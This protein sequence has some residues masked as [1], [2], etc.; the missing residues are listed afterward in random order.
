MYSEILDD[1]IA[2]NEQKNDFK[3]Y[4]EIDPEMDA[5]ITERFLNP[6]TV[7]NINGMID[8]IYRNINDIDHRFTEEYKPTIRQVILYLLDYCRIMQ[9]NGEQYFNEQQ[10]KQKTEYFFEDDENWEID[11]DTPRNIILK[12]ILTPKQYQKLN[13]PKIIDFE[14][15]DGG[16]RKRRKNRK[17]RKTNKSKKRRRSRRIRRSRKNRKEQ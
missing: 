12:K 16:S 14:A 11:M 5:K 6:F 3:R 15:P 10:I 9:Q 1:I 17:T 13:D 2:E 4:E 8:A 7:K